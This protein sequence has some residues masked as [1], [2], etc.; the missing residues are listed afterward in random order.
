MGMADDDPLPIDPGALAS[1]MFVGH[2]V[3]GHEVTPLVRAARDVGY[4]TAGGS[5][6]GQAVQDVMVAFMLA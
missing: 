1:S 3:A 4:P 5:Q 6:I 2:V